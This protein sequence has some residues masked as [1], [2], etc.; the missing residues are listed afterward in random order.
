MKLLITLLCLITTIPTCVSA[1]YKQHRPF[2][3]Y[4]SARAI[5]SERVYQRIY[6]GAGKHFL[7]GTADLHYVGTDT[8]GAPVD[9][10]ISKKVRA[11]GSYV[12]HAGTFFPVALLSDNSMIAFNVEFLG[13]FY[14]LAIDSVFFHP[15]A[16]YKG[17][18]SI[19][20][21]G[22]PISL[23]FKSGGDVSLSKV[24]KSMF[25]IGAGAYF[26]GT[27]SYVA[28]QDQLPFIP[29]PFAKVEAGFFAGLAFK[30]RGVAYF[31]NANFID[32]PTGHIFG[33]DQLTTKTHSGYGFQL[34]VIMMPFS[35]GW[36][37]EEWY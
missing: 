11:K 6:I 9:T 35:N 29:I 22:V 18:E 28:Y 27:N 26:G 5:G 32:R 4:Y 1:Q 30:L 37:T 17:S 7:T 8:T 25:A 15:G 20:M 10:S 34:S 19:T 36:R 16:L 12:F 24:R 2:Q 13:A 14:Y 33:E 31:G 23:E 21:L 3:D